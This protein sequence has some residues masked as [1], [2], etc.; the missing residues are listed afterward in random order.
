M[1]TKIKQYNRI[2]YMLFAVVLTCAQSVSAQIKIKN[3]HSNVVNGGIV[4]SNKVSKQSGSPEKGTQHASGLSI[5]SPGDI[6]NTKSIEVTGSVNLNAGRSIK[7]GSPTAPANIHAS[8]SVTL[9]A[10]TIHNSGRIT[11]GSGN[12]NISTTNLVNSGSI[13]AKSG[14]INISNHSGSLLLIDNTNGSITGKTVTLK[15]NDSGKSKNAPLQNGSIKLH[16]GTIS[17]ETINIGGTET[18]VSVDTDEINGKVN[19]PGS[20]A[21]IRSKQK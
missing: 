7:N 16:G 14:D 5:S 3:G 18:K 10:P 20:S 4:K 2:Q 6:S 12:V 11:A 19:M 8:S 21:V 17:G 9:N 13:T 1:A 15:V